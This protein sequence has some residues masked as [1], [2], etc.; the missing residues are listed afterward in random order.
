[1]V[2]YKKTRL[3]LL[4]GGIQRPPF[5]NRKRFSGDNIA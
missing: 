3:V 2:Y 5:P 4:K 1:M